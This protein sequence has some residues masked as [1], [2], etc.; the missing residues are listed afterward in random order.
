MAIR[1]GTVRGTLAWALV[2]GALMGIIG[3]FAFDGLPT[4]SAQTD[5]T[6]PTISSV[7]ITSDTGDDD[8]YFDDDGVYGIDDIIKVTV[9]F[10][11]NIAVT[12]APQLE[13][14]IGGSGK[15]A[16]YESVT[17][18]NVV[19]S[20]TVAEGVSDDDGIAIGADKLTL[21]GGTIE[22]AADNAADLSHGA[23]VVQTGHKVD[24]VRPTISAV[25]FVSST[26]GNDGVYSAG[27]RL[28]TDAVF[29]EDVVATGTPQL[30][31]DFE[32]TPK[33]VDFDY[34]V[35]KCE[36]TCLFSP[37]PFAVRGIRL[38]FTY[39]VLS[40]DSDSDGVAVGGDA[41]SLNG[42]AIKDAAGNDAVLT[43][44]AVAEDSNFVVDGSADIGGL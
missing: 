15:A 32:G 41:V 44:D 38:V 14:D 30:E 36:A 20:Y 4:V 31:L 18:T 17:T 1:I 22:D 27:E 16:A 12:G 39:T 21:N 7:A 28:V 40:G 23:L 29:S 34:A 43:H 13:L 2:V 9:T 33:L 37:G 26:G 5:T 10:S 6:A 3:L 11:E 35:P 24:G 8:S 19:F 25:S 42:G